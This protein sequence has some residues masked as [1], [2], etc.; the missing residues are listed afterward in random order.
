VSLD[1][2]LG[3][4][5][6]G[7]VRA[8]NAGQAARRAGL[9]LG[10]AALVLL[11]VVLF[12]PGLVTWH[13]PDATDVAHAFAHPSAAHP[14]GTD[15]L[16][17]DVYTRVVFGTRISLVIAVSAVAIGIGGGLLLGLTAAMGRGVV[18]G[19]L[20]RAV[21]VL[22]A[23]PELLLALLVMAMLGRGSVKVALAV[24]IAAVPH[25]ARL[26]RGQALA[27]LRAEY[28]DAARV[29]GVRPVSYAVRHVL[30]NVAGPLTVMAA[31]G[32]GSSM[33]AAAG[34]S[35]LGLGPAEPTPAWG[36]MLAGGEDFLGTA[37]WI[38]VFPGL[39]VVTV[40]LALTLLGRALQARAVR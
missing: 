33:T 1:L 37:W 5:P 28:V 9:L 3:V 17:R 25:F 18:D 36:T 11:A 12:W 29:L 24:G 32:T 14:F 8:A 22:L 30:P 38:A 4:T 40:V 39:A 34:L 21:D 35:L 13:Q 27:V 31:I 23:F 16:G 15:Q 10:G 19:V 7:T 20:M 6:A 2:D 26:V